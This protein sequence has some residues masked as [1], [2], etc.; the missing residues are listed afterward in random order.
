MAKPG[1]GSGSDPAAQFLGDNFDG[2]A[3]DLVA[4]RAFGFVQG[5]V[6]SACTSAL[7]PASLRT[8]AP[9]AP[10]RSS[11]KT[12]SF[13]NSNLPSGSSGMATCSVP[14]K[15]SRT[16]FSNVREPSRSVEDAGRPRHA[17]LKKRD[18]ALTE[19]NG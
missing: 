3:P 7:A 4:A 13:V 12:R 1:I 5:F 6:R 15:R 19:V 18:R 14:L 9:A 16:C 11:A 17:V 10:M 8:M 2:Y